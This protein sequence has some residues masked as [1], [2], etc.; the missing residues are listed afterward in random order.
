MKYFGRIKKPTENPAK[1]I[2]HYA[3]NIIKH[4]ETNAAQY[5]QHTY[6]PINLP[7]P[8]IADQTVVEKAKTRIAKC[9]Y[10]MKY[11]EKPPLRNTLVNPRPH[12]RQKKRAQN[13]K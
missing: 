11:T 7:H 1:K 12:T 13:L 2:E 4:P 8:A 10:R 5:D 6:Y 9:T 3:R